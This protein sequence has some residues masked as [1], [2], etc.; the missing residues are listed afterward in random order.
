MVVKAISAL[1]IFSLITSCTYQPTP[2]KVVQSG[3]FKHG[4]QLEKNR[5]G[6]TEHLISQTQHVVSVKLD[7]GS[8]PE[9]AYNMLVLHAAN[10]ATNKGYDGFT[11]NNG[12]HGHWCLWKSRGGGPKFYYGGPLA[13]ASIEFVD[14]NRN[15]KKT[16][17]IPA[18]NVISNFA[19]KVSQDI[20]AEEVE[21]NTEN[22]VQVCKK[23]FAD[24]LSA[25]ANYRRGSQR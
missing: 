17:L 3:N 2:Y 16:N 12:T 7:S 24:D 4:L 5:F 9:R 13:S 6:V 23:K 19:S 21:F 18:N 10:M 15:N 11:M 22:S 20:T 25:K 8:S 14:I 1:L